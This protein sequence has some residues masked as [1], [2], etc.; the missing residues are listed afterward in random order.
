MDVSDEFGMWVHWNYGMSQIVQNMYPIKTNNWTYHYLLTIVDWINE[1]MNVSALKIW[2]ESNHTKNVL[3]H[4][5][6]MH[7][8]LCSWQWLIE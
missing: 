5:K 2:N 8:P 6:E 1:T 4:K 3:I 7:Q